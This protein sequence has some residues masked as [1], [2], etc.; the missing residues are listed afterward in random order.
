MDRW[1]DTRS[2]TPSTCRLPA[3]LLQKGGKGTSGAQSTAAHVGAHRTMS[4]PHFTCNVFEFK[5][6][7]TKSNP[8][9]QSKCLQIVQTSICI[10]WTLAS[11]LQVLLL[12]SKHEN[13]QRRTRQPHAHEQLGRHHR[14]RKQLPAAAAGGVHLIK[15][16][17]VGERTCRRCLDRGPVCQRV[18]CSPKARGLASKADSFL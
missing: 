16:G 2:T 9:N 17:S 6:C 12:H 1:G 18:L 8:K 15:S 4:K 3:G 7:R 10:R 14:S 5:R 11:H 13:P